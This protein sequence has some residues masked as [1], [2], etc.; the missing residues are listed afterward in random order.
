[1]T[2]TKGLLSDYSPMIMTQIKKIKANFQKDS[3]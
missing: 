1:M 3:Y 2:T